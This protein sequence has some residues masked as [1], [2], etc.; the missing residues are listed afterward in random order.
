MAVASQ[1]VKELKIFSEF[2]VEFN[3]FPIVRYT[4]MAVVTPRAEKP[5]YILSSDFSELFIFFCLVAKNTVCIQTTAFFMRGMNL[6][7]VKNLFGILRGLN[8][9]LKLI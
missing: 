1:W 4:S 3:L 5:S 7:T 9:C 8:R 6:R 2:Q